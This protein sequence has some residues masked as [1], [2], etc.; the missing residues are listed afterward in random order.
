[1]RLGFIGGLDNMFSHAIDQRKSLG[2]VGWDGREG[3]DPKVQARLGYMV[4]SCI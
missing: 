3:E 1:M 4:R 2:V